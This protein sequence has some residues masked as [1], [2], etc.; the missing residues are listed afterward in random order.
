MLIDQQYSVIGNVFDTQGNLIYIEKL[1]HIANDSGGKLTTNYHLPDKTEI[2]YKVVNYDCRPTSPEFELLDL[3][4]GKSEG[5]KWNENQLLTFRNGEI[6]PLSIPSGPTIFDAGFDNFVKLN[7]EVL[8]QDQSIIASYLSVRNERFI[9]LK[10]QKSKVPD[11]LKNEPIEN[12]VF[13][14]IESSNPFLKLITASLYIGYDK[15]S[16]FLKYYSGP[17]N[18]PIMKNKQVIIKYRNA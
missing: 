10:L 16:R 13:F 6:N 3:I 7:W 18:L 1:D 17:S 4:N 12:L 2:A 8:L 15:H 9:E 11:S 14:K 5:A